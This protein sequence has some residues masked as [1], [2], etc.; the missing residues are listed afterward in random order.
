MSSQLVKTDAKAGAEVYHGS[1]ICR[2]KALEFFCEV[3]L[4]RGLLPLEGVEECGFVRETGFVWVKRKKK[5]EYL[6]KTT[7]SLSSYAPEISGY[8]EKGKMKKITGVKA[9]D[10]H[11]WFALTEMRIDDPA[12]GMIYIKTSM[13]AGKN[14]PIKSFEEEYDKYMV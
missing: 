1:E 3:G 4:P 12:S 10:F 5:Y 9:K 8:V 6:Y 14:V 11:I 7:G 2:Q 13:G